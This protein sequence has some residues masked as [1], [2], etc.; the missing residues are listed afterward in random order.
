MGKITKQQL[1]PSLLEY[2]N[3]NKGG[4]NIT[5]KKHSVVIQQATDR[6]NIEIDGY[7]KYTDLL[8]VYKNTVFLEDGRMYKISDDSLYITNP[9]GNW[10]AESLFNF[11]VIK[12]RGSNGGNNNLPGNGSFEILDGSITENKL[13]QNLKDKINNKSNGGP[14]NFEILDGSITENKLDQNLKEK[15]NI[16]GPKTWGALKNE[17]GKTWGNLMGQ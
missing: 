16:G 9:N 5:F 1:S 8:M 12:N 13:D 6:V 11:I 2:I 7:N 15:L 10:E 14:T 17:L 3:S 4:S